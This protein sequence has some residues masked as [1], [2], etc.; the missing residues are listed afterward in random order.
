MIIQKDV[1]L[2]IKAFNK[3][4]N[5]LVIPSSKFN[6]IKLKKIGVKTYL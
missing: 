6:F 2:I 5:N 1:K 3:V 4:W